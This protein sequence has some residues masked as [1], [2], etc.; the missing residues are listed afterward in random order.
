MC[1]RHVHSSSNLILWESWV[2]VDKDHFHS[3]LSSKLRVET[4]HFG[5]SETYLGDI[6]KMN[7]RVF[8]GTCKNLILLNE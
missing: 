3:S 7:L 8:Q 6:S 2:E 1:L 4:T 5:T